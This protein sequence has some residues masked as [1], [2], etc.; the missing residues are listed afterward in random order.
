MPIIF[1]QKLSAGS[2]ISVWKITEPLSFFEQTVTAARPILH[3]EVRKRHL[4]ARLALLQLD[5]GLSITA[6][7]VAESGKPY[8]EA[9]CP[10]VS[11]SH[12]E[13]YAAA[14]LS[15]KVEVGVDIEGVGE[16]IMRI[17]HK[18]LN[19]QEQELLQQS[20]GLI[21]LQDGVE[22]ATWL[23]RCWSAKE[24]LFKW[25]GITAVDFREHLLLKEVDPS[26]RQL[27]FDCVK[28]KRT[29]AVQYVDC[30]NSVLTWV[31]A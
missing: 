29:V 14:I 22:S 15:K 23:T 3:E 5:P 17:R 7:Q 20:V 24:T 12:T 26:S 18:F 6:M 8:F 1:Q 30:E 9:G 10:F 21:S 31:V 11:F 16:R 27:I 4:A 19:E 25:Q 2:S 13:G 28:V